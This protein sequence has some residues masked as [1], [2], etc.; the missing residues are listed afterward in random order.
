MSS[1]TIVSKTKE[2]APNS[3]KSSSEVTAGEDDVLG[4]VEKCGIC[5]E[6]VYY[7]RVHASSGFIATVLE[8]L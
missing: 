8:F 4:D 6:N 2:K 5:E 7:V 3:E 1:K